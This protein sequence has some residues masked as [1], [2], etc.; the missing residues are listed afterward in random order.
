MIKINLLPP[1]F[2]IV[3]KKKAVKA[4]APAAPTIKPVKTYSGPAIPWKYIGIGAGALFMLLTLY[5]DFDYYRLNKKVKVLKAQWATTQPQMHSLK[6]LEEE[7]GR[8]LVPEQNFLKTHVL[9]KAPTTSVLQKLSEALPEGMWLENFTMNNAGKARSFRIQGLAINLEK[10]TNIEQI[11]EYLQKL[12]TVIPGSQ[13]TY[14]TS[15][16]IFDRTPATAFMAEYQWQ[17]D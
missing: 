15:K 7:V 10:K 17:A 5:F 13:V 8:T 16:Q 11:E 2:R 3:K 4:A 9:S 12:K 6:M 1:T 14:S